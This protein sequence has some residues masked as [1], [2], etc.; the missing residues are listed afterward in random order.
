[1]WTGVGG[2]SIDQIMDSS[3]IKTICFRI[4]RSALR[5]GRLCRCDHV[6][7]ADGETEDSNSGLA[8]DIGPECG[9]E[10]GHEQACHGFLHHRGDLSAWWCINCPHEISKIK[11]GPSHSIQTEFAHSWY[12]YYSVIGPIL[13][14]LTAK[15]GYSDQRLRLL[16]AKP[17]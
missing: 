5:W 6:S 9:A 2:R 4:Q 1:M 14:L 11:L 13:R 10:G 15:A 17:G 16:T 3:S 12:T 7:H 8:V